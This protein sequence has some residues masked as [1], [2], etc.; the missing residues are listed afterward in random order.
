MA[1]TEAASVRRLHEPTGD[2]L[3]GLQQLVVDSHW[4]QLPGDW[5]LFLSLGAVY[6]VRGEGGRIVASGAVLPM[7]ASAGGAAGVS[8]I[9]MILVSPAVRGQGLGRAVFARCL[10]HVQAEGRVPMLDATPQGEALYAKF[11]FDTA[12]RFMRWRRPASGAASAPMPAEGALDAL[13]LLDQRALG[14]ERRAL[15]A[16]LAAREGARCVRLG[17]AFALL[18]PGRTAVQAGPL[19]AI[20]EAEGTALLQAIAAAVPEVL[21]IDV[22]ESRMNMAS[23]LRAC[24]FAPERPFARMSLAGGLPLPGTETSLIQAVAGPEYA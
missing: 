14:F 19:H 22:P 17:E 8:W 11:G 2:D 9:S 13:A 16:G 4:N 21:V 23:T 24:G 6:A 15:L 1:N 10:A 20:E 18:R 7:G 5:A 12:W 3:A